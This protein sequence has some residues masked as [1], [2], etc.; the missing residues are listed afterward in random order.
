[1][2]GYLS[3]RGA[4][5]FT[6]RMPYLSLF[7]PKLFGI[8]RPLLVGLLLVTSI[9][10]A[11]SQNRLVVMSYNVENLFDTLSMHTGDQEFT[12]QGEY[13]WDSRKYQHKIGEV[14][15]A[16]AHSSE[17]EVP[18]IIALQEIENEQVLAD[19]LRHRSLRTIEYRSAITHGNDP[20]GIQVGLLY[21]SSWLVCDTLQEWSLVHPSTQKPLTTRHLLYLRL[22][23]SA[24]NRFHIVA[25]HLPSMRNRNTDWTA[26]RQAI[27]QFITHKKDSIAHSDPKGN[28]IILGDWNST[29][30]QDRKICP[31]LRNLA[32]AEAPTSWQALYDLMGN[33]P[34]SSPY[35]SYY[36]RK[37][38]QYI[39]RIIVGSNLIDGQGGWKYLYGSARA[40]ASPLMRLNDSVQRPK[41]SFLGTRF[42]GGS[43]D[44]FPIIAIFTRNE[45]TSRITQ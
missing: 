21:R 33:P 30:R 9:G 6:T 40:T 31:R 34:K 42:A 41:R 13:Q 4:P 35:G 17:W 44:H 22:R 3:I 5:L 12:P 32:R 38:W 26:I 39:D 24:Q 19:L 36:F 7:L 1:M 25:C 8:I 23:D 37:R 45:S 16:I 27:W 10:M 11:L 18:D 28:F 15:Q 20:R 14:A 43:S 29:F 2:R